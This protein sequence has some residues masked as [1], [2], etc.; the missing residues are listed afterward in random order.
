MPNK[1][2]HTLLIA[3]ITALPG[4]VGAAELSTL[5]TTPQERQIIDNN[6]YKT[7]DKPAPAPVRTEIEDDSPTL[8]LARES[9]TYEYQISGITISSDGPHTVWINSQIYEDGQSLEDSSEIKVLTGEEIKVRIT[10]PDGQQYYA[11][12]GESL[13]VTYLAPVRN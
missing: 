4:L 9:V 6:R 11:T 3:L 12:S 2:R 13:Q 8:V 7:D 5:F 10:A 1:V